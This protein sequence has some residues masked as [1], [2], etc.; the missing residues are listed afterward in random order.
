MAMLLLRLLRQQLLQMVAMVGV[1]LPLLQ[2]LLPH[3]KVQN[4]PHEL[5]C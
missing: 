2:Q 4:A 1:Q 5:Y 3:H